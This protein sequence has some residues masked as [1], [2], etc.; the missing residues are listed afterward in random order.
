MPPLFGGTKFGH[1]K[2]GHSCSSVLLRGIGSELPIIAVE[3]AEICNQRADVAEAAQAL[4]IDF[5]VT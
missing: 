5:S 1:Y 4:S 3:A 2:G